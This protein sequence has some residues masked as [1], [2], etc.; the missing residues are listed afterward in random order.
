[1]RTFL[2]R[3]R[4]RYKTAAVLV[5][6]V[7]FACGCGGGGK[8]KGTWISG[9][10]FYKDAPLTGGTIAF[11]PA[12]GKGLPN[13]VNIAPDGKFA[14]SGLEPGEM[15]VTVE[16][17]S[18]SGQRGANQ[19]SSGKQAPNMEV[20]MPTYVQIPRSYAEASSTPLRVTLKGGKNEQD[21]KLNE[22]GK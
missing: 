18:I 4:L 9:T 3:A 15:K 16:T 17:E 2:T 20:K 12:D 19:G 5:L 6:S 13:Q 22:S 8:S 7:I 1:M 11:H 21:F 10:V 14:V